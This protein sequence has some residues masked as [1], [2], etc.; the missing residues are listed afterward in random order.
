MAALKKYLPIL[1]V[2]LAIIAVITLAMP[3]AERSAYDFYY[4]V[5]YSGSE[6]AFGDGDYPDFSFINVVKYLLVIIG[7]ILCIFA[8]K[9]GKDKLNVTAAI[10][11][12]I[13]AVL[14]FLTTVNST[15]KGGELTLAQQGFTLASGSILGG[16]M[17]ILAAAGIMVPY[18]LRKLG[19]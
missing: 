10:L 4:G 13:S 11:F 19:K 9:E 16:I 2:I 1:S 15:L 8:R 18:V 3:A 17:C 14:F 6:V 12:E 5:T 7:A